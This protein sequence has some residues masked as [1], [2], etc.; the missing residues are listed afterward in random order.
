MYIQHVFCAAVFCV[1]FLMQLNASDLSPR[2]RVSDDASPRGV[3]GSPKKHFKAS[4]QSAF[5]GNQSLRLQFKSHVVSALNERDAHIKQETAARKKAHIVGR[6]IYTSP[7]DKQ[8]IE[9]VTVNGQPVSK[10]IETLEACPSAREAVCTMYKKYK[11]L[12]FTY[13]VVDS[14]TISVNDVP[15]IETV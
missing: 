15:R 6:W 8:V 9:I 5:D 11:F 13:I 10:F 14:K 3:Q 7:C 4:D 1:G 2:S 12:T